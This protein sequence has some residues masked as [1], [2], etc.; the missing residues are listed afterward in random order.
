MRSFTV[1]SPARVCLYGDHQDYLS[2][3]VIAG[4]IDRYMHF[5]VSAWDEN[6]FELHLIDL[7]E[8]LDIKIDSS[9]AYTQT[10]AID[11]F[12]SGLRVAARHGYVAKHGLRVRIYSNIPIN[13]GVSSSSALVVG[14]IY[15][16]A[17]AFGNGQ[18]PE[19]DQLGQMAFEA[20]VLEHQSPGG[21]MDQY[22]I[23]H[24][25]LVHIET[26][27]QIRVHP[28]KIPALNLVLADSNIKKQT[29][30]TIGSVRELTTEAIK[31]IQTQNSSFSLIAART[32]ALDHELDHV[33]TDLKP[34]ATAAVR[35][36]EITLEA[37][38]ELKSQAPDVTILGQLMSAH[39]QQLSQVLKVSHV[40]ID[41]WMSLG[42]EHG[43]Y[44]AKIVG[45]G[46]GGCSVFL[47][48]QTKEHSLS[49]LLLASGVHAAY[50]IKIS[51]GCHH[52]WAEPIN[53][54]T[55]E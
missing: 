14:W 33:R 49:Q 3:P 24:G 55:H 10:S 42:L 38:Q 48:P 15:T 47:V 13:A 51:Q 32:K 12:R 35:N 45:S 21:Q 11:F 52:S 28:L 20:E 30:S 26:G 53:M 36:H 4:A 39:H 18:I 29:L 37:L 9:Q 1:H 50:P 27:T 25:G 8:T 54:I 23:A 46:H 41:K 31:E 7:G 17:L 2:L 6:S 44:G 16:L 40:Q 5:E 22:T 34:Y 19:P 43:A